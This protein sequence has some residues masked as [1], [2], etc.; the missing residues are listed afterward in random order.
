VCI[1]INEKYAIMQTIGK[2]TVIGYFVMPRLQNPK[3][4]IRFNRASIFRDFIV[5]DR[6]SLFRVISCTLL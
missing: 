6:A 2:N 4:V 3:Y 5:N 1:H